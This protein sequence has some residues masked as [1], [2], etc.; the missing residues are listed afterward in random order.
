MGMREKELRLALICYGGVSL[1][2]Y[3][4]GV[5]REAWHLV[6][7]SRG[8]H[9]GSPH[10]DGSQGIYRQLMEEIERETGVRM[11]VLNDIIAGSSAG[12]INGIFL[13]QAIATGQSL[14][15]LTDLWL[16]TADVDRLVDPDARPLSRFSKFWATPIAWA[17]LRR[18][19]GTI[20]RTVSRD[21]RDEVAMKLSR[22]VR[23]RWFKPP[24]GGLQLSGLLYDALAT[25]AET[26]A[27][28]P[29]LPPGQPLDLFVTVTD[30]YGHD[31]ILRLNSPPR[32]V[33]T[34][35]RLT[36]SFSTRS[37]RAPTNWPPSPNYCLQRARLQA[38]PARFR[39]LLS[40][41]WISLLKRAVPHGIAARHF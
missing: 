25:M 13:A 1:A 10:A 31:E 27:D 17:L 28:G 12:G 8:F 24:F 36:I 33:E 21:A 23:A 9:N 40:A 11:R 18:K 2:I 19:K 20:E 6:R 14:E 3:M 29:L 39:P 15:P 4:H 34:E 26:K 38:F 30:F 37:D 41:S 35:H 7:A 5:T 22:F 32:V 16:Q